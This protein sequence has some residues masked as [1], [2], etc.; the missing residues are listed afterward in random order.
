M[1]KENASLIE[2]MKKGEVRGRERPDAEEG[3][4]DGKEPLVKDTGKR[5]EE[6]RPSDDIRIEDLEVP[7]DQVDA[8]PTV[9]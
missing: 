5:E 2:S 9:G 7:K 1:K 6:K 8:K 3:V 4:P